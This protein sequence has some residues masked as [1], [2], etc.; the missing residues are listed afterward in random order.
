MNSKKNQT[1]KQWDS[2]YNSYYCKCFSHCQDEK[3]KSL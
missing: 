1:V 2:A 3:R